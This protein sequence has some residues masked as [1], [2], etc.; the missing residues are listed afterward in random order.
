MVLKKIGL[1]VLGLALGLL[2]TE[3]ILKYDFVNKMFCRI[4]VEG[5]CG[6]YELSD[7]PELV[8]LPRPNTGEY[9][10]YGY[11]GKEVPLKHTDQ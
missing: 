9:N 2:I 7:D 6:T 3:H 5:V 8:Y 4:D 11:R 1:I 10:K